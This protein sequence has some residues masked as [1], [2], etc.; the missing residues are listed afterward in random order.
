MGETTAISWTKAMKDSAA[1]VIHCEVHAGVRPHANT[2]P[3]SQCGHVHVDGERRHEWHYYLEYD[4]EHWFSVIVLCTR[5]HHSHSSKAR[6]THC[7]RGHAF[8]AANT[9]RNKNGT[10]RC[11]ACQVERARTRAKKLKAARHARGLRNRWT[12]Q[13]RASNG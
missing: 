7:V 12:S 9:Y 2:V 3:C 6:Q 13:G 4:R 1:R 11:I 8:D 5:C 10:R